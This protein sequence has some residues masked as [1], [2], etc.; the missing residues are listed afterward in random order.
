MQLESRTGVFASGSYWL[1]AA[2]REHQALIFAT[3]KAVFQACS[4]NLVNTNRPPTPS[5][6]LY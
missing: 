2:L 1:Q 3:L 6:L 4:G 5:P